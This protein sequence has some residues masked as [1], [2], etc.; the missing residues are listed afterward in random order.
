MR[1]RLFCA[2]VGIVLLAAAG[3]ARQP[4]TYDFLI[5]ETSARDVSFERVV[6]VGA[7]PDPMQLSGGCGAESAAYPVQSIVLEG[8]ESAHAS[9]VVVIA[10]EA[11]RPGTILGSL[12]PLGACTDNG[13]GYLK[14]HGVVQ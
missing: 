12:K 5:P 11:I 10:E 9:G 3:W 14:F 7:S 4:A 13:V 2:V 6:I 1:F 8:A